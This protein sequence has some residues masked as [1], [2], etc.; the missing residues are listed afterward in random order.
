[1]KK[2]SIPELQ[3]MPLEQVCLTILAGN[4][5]TDSMSF[6]SQAPQPPSNESVTLALKVLEETNAIEP[7]PNTRDLTTIRI[8]QITPLGKHLAKLPVDIRLGKML[9]FGALFQTLDKTLTIAASLSS[10][11]PFS[12]NIDQAQQAS[13]AHKAFL[14]PT[15][16]FLTV[17]NVWDAYRDA[18]SSSISNGRKFCGRNY[19]NRSA[20]I[21]IQDARNQF[22]Q[23][24]IQIGFINPSRLTAKNSVLNS[25][26]DTNGSNEKI[27]SA[28]V[29][30]GLYPNCAHIISTHPDELPTLWQQNNQLWFHK[31]SVFC[32][33]KKIE[34]SEWVIFHEKF[35]TH[36]VLVST[37]CLVNPFSLLLF[38]KTIDIKHLSRKVE[39]DGWIELNI[40]AQTSVIFKEL[41]IA[42]SKELNRKI[43]YVDSYQEN[44][45]LLSRITKLLSC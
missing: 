20:F 13:A 25:C 10:K 32:K 31:S 34:E 7:I 22:I 37:S 12:T 14:H 35:A 42:M 6:L 8:E 17:C 44:D 40:P 19:L 2:Q 4:L 33:R 23:L 5:A 38:G 45:V 26:Y 18:C 41:R 9:I 30:A 27:L 36:K 24:L 16:D 15:S 21:E 3:K 29:C 43:T 28:I 1:M 39:V 11:S